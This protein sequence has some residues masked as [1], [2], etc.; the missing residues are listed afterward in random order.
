MILAQCVESRK[1]A[2]NEI[3]TVRRHLRNLKGNHEH[4]A[5]LTGVPPQF[6]RRVS[7]GAPMPYYTHIRVLYDFFEN[8]QAGKAMVFLS[9]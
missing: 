6:L 3:N 8:T 4:V 9:E 7:K 2:D 5:R 1:S